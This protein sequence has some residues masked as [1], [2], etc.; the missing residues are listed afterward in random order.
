MAIGAASEREADLRRIPPQ[1]RC[2]FAGPRKYSGGVSCTWRAKLRFGR[3]SL[4]LKA[5]QE[6]RRKTRLS[7]WAFDVS[8]FSTLA[9]HTFPSP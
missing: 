8:L 1:P 5:T 6:A 2:L 7:A 9:P 3:E 4:S